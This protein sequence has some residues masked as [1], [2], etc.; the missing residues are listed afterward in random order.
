MELENELKAEIDFMLNELLSGN[1]C[2]DNRENTELRNKSIRICKALNL[3]K[4]TKNGKQYE[5][6]EKAVL[7][8]NNGGIEKYLINDKKEKNIDSDIKNLTLKKLKFEQ[9]PAKFWWLIIFIMAIISV[10][11]T[12]VNNQIEKSTNLQETPK[13]EKLLSK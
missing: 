4:P 7:V 5:L 3:I 1:A 13:T 6:S 8:L 10:L 11:T 2:S 9:F 12:W